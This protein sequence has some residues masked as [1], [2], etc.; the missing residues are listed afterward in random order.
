M[1]ERV[2][3]LDRAIAGVLEVAE[4]W[5]RAACAGKG[6]DPLSSLAGEEWISGPMTATRNLR[7]MSEA[8]QAGGAPETHGHVDAPD[9]QVGRRRLPAEPARAAMYSGMTVDVWIEP[10]QAC[11]RRAGSTA[12][13][14][15]RVRAG[16]TCLV[17]GAGN[18][19]S[20]GPLDVIYKLFV[21]DEVA[22]LKMNPVNDYLAP[23]FERAFAGLIERGVWP[24]CAA[25]PRSGDYLCTHP[26]VDSI[27]LTGSDRT[28]DA[29]VWGA[30]GRNR[31]GARPAANRVS[32]SR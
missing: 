3:L 25:G 19:S 22:V 6:I 5:V 20:I 26:Q 10:G 1:P 30:T 9:G 11:H 7:L 23:V 8:L 14:R 27:H 15:R 31:S 16:R 4:E 2:A 12:T 29:I 28:H 21:E 24:S 17:L 18:V 32:T 13:R